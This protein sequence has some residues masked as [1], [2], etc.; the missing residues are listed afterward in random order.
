MPIKE[1]EADSNHIGPSGPRGRGACGSWPSSGPRQGS[2]CPCRAFCK[3]APSL[4][5]Y[6]AAPPSTIPLGKPFAESRPQQTYLCNKPVLDT[7][8]LRAAAWLRPSQRALAGHQSEAPALRASLRASQ[9]HD[10][11]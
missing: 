3:I 4:T 2:P 10:E 11:T 1:K 9:G 6:Y 7:L 8:P 5:E